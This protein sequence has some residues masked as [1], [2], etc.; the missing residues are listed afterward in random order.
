MFAYAYPVHAYNNESKQPNEWYS[1]I[2]YNNNLP[3]IRTNDTRMNERTN[4]KK[5]KK[6]LKTSMLER[7]AAKNSL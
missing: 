3:F 1:K 2:K 5:K 4:E 7:R 6:H